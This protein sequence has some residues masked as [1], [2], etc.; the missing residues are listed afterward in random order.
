LC[1]HSLSKLSKLKNNKMADEFRQIITTVNTGDNWDEYKFRI[2]AHAFSTGS[3]GILDGTEVAPVAPAAGATA[4]ETAAYNTTRADFI[5]R[6]GELYGYLVKT[7]SSATSPLIHLV[8][9]GQTRQCWQALNAHFEST[10]RAAVMQTI[11]R[12]FHVQ[13]KDNAPDF[14][15]RIEADAENLRSGIAALP[16]GGPDLV[17]LISI[18][19]MLN[20]LPDEFTGLAQNLFTIPDLRM[21]AAR[22]AVIDAAERIKFQKMNNGTTVATA[23]STQGIKMN[24]EEQKICTFCG[25]PR[26]DEAHCF[27]KY[28]HLRPL[29]STTTGTDAVASA[30][31]AF[32]TGTAAT[33]ATSEEQQWANHPM[34]SS[35]PWKL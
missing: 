4:E 31:S 12:L 21:N 22:A 20:G 1:T 34:F 17:E 9:A 35:S 2:I 30:K 27:K 33:A 10:S 24:F 19:V 18:M 7:Q 15:T 32:G 26:H 16:A 6:N 8:P 5:K 3:H 23:F 13:F 25:K 28:P 14:I 11:F 29:P